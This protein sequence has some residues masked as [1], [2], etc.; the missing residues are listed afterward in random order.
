MMSRNHP[1]LYE[2]LKERNR[3]GHR[4]R[5]DFS[6]TE[7]IEAAASV[8]MAEPEVPPVATYEDEPGVP[9]ET[10]SSE[11]LPV[12]TKRSV[13][14][15]SL[16]RQ[17]IRLSYLQIGAGLLTSIALVIGAYFLGH[18]RGRQAEAPVMM[19]PL[20]SHG[21]FYSIKLAEIA[22]KDDADSCQ[23]YLI[24]DLRLQGVMLL[25]VEGRYHVVV[26]EF[27]D[28]QSAK[29]SEILQQVKSIVGPIPGVPK[30][31]P[32]DKAEIKPY[33]V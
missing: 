21:T 32:F 13:G 1:G 14:R 2:L 30:E 19:R 11:A 28:V 20:A 24:K 12:M 33:R 29:D 23:K 17:S 6:E 26:G 18:S 8:A 5:S 9:S 22:K 16:L 10:A 4:R 27:Q 3:R 31:T 15:E 25:E 7:T